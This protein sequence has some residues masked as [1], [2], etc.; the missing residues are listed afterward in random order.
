[1]SNREGCGTTK[2]ND[3]FSILQA[4][5][6]TNQSIKSCIIIV[7]IW[8]SET[9]KIVFFLR[10]LESPNKLCVILHSYWLILTVLFEITD[11]R[12]CRLKQL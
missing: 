7:D 3:I 4:I 9:V 8:L 10:G 5:F 1:M 12:I 11:L 6:I 2:Y